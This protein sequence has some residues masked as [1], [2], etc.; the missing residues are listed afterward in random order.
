[1]GTSPAP[2]RL[3]GA[4]VAPGNHSP[5][6]QRP[7]RRR[8]ARWKTP[9]PHLC[10]LGHMTATTCRRE[11]NPARDLCVGAASRRGDGAF[12]ASRPFSSASRLFALRASSPL[13]GDSSFLI[14]ESPLGRRP[15]PQ[16]TGLQHFPYTAPCV[17]V[18]G[19]GGR[20]R[21]RGSAAKV[22]CPTP[23][24]RRAARVQLSPARPPWSSWARPV[25]G[26]CRLSGSA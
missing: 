9:G 20:G 17:Q 15:L 2:R 25:L 10:P 21:G 11:G 8:P 1:M 6:A 26:T 13:L 7:G 4:Q 24:N 18:Q 14:P 22:T 16:V 5:Q 23:T 3:R 12:I 19:P